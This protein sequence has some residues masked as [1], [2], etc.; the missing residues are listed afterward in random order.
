MQRTRRISWA[1]TA[2]RAKLEKPISSLESLR[3]KIWG[4]VGV[5]AIKNAILKEAKSESEKCFLLVE[6]FGEISRVKVTEA[7]G[8]LDSKLVQVELGKVKSDLRDEIKSLV[9][10]QTEQFQKYFETVLRARRV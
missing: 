9:P 1:L 8:F 2:L 5:S 7:E 6:L 10:L 3:W 4:P